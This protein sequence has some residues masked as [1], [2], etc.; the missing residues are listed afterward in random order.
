MKKIMQ[1]SPWPICRI[2]SYWNICHLKS[3]K[4]EPIT[5]STDCTK[6]LSVA[7]AW[8]FDNLEERHLVPKAWGHSLRRRKSGLCCPNTC[9]EHTPH[10]SM[11]DPRL[12]PSLLRYISS[13]LLSRIN[14]YVID[15]SA[16]RK[17]ARKLATNGDTV[18]QQE[19]ENLM[20]RPARIC[21]EGFGRISCKPIFQYWEAS[22][23]DYRCLFLVNPAKLIIAR[24]W[25]S[26]P[27]LSLSLL[28][29]KFYLTYGADVCGHAC[30][31][32][33]LNEISREKEKCKL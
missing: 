33:Y 22:Q 30:P 3:H 17:D 4:I 19:V 6:V 18:I 12:T 31:T 5:R 32:S 23:R 8:S 24:L 27:E 7:M 25:V 14:L 21:N 29:S 13:Y 10:Q 2:A 20:T 26:A 16:R 11:R 28:Y 15:N 1:I 9:R